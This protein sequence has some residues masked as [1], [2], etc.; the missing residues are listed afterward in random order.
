M[1]VRFLEIAKRE[2]DEAISYYELQL[3]GLGDVFLLE[4][5]ATLHRIQ[6]YPKAWH[7]PGEQVRRCFLRRFPY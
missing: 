7:S 2:L 5:V 3:P 1:I 4:T 6:A